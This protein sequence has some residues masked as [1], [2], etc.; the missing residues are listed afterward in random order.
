MFVSAIIVAGGRGTRVGG[1]VPKQMLDLGG[2][3]M[4]QRSIDAFDRHP[5]VDEIV[6]VTPGV[7]FIEPDPRREGDASVSFPM[8]ATHELRFA[9]GG[10]RRQD[11]VAS[12]FAECSPRAD[13][14]LVHD[15]ARP[16]VGSGVISRVI[17][18]AGAYGAAIPAMRASDTI[19][20][21][22]GPG[23]PIEETIPRDTIWLAQTP[24]GFQRR[25]L[26]DAIAAGAST[27]ATDEAMLAERAGHP[28]H[29]VEG[30]PENVKI[31]TDADL[32]RARQRLGD[33]VRVG[34]GYD[35][36][37]LV[38]GRALVLAGVPIPF[39]KGP[40][41]HS[42]GDVIAHSLCDAIFG[43]AAMGDIGHHFPDRDPQWKNAEGVDLL[44]RA[45]AIIAG[46]GWRVAS[47]DVTVLLE[48]PKLSSFIEAI[49]S[50][51]ATVLKIHR[52]A[53]SVKAKTN[54]GV[55]AVGRG[56]AIA[57]HAVAVLT[58]AAGTERVEG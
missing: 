4:L 35:L 31:T 32:V 34:T 54:E 7:S 25:I 43:A 1:V 5:Q 57:A 6:V 27:E 41:G 16:F 22:A 42:D 47:A 2:R 55:D 23:A 29:I 19:K 11:S 24:Q 15:A 26:A 14:V 33:A 20:R 48:R 3:S 51:L 38:E 8:E 37:R 12:G 39:D 53:V 56:E 10:E 9:F 52:D 21:A 17:E 44:G 50:R 18:A 28:V 40:L 49:R 58:A 45:V 36:H 30:D 13:V 46:R